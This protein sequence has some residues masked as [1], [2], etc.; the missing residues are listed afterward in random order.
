[1][2]VKES[3]FE[4]K[5]T[6]FKAVGTAMEIVLPLPLPL[7]QIILRSPRTFFDS[8]QPSIAFIIQDALQSS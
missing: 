3:C 1:M 5:S 7:I 2:L 8:P 4:Q 6:T